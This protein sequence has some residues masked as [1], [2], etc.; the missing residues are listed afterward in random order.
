[1]K[2]LEQPGQPSSWRGLV[3]TYRLVEDGSRTGIQCLGCGLTSW[4]RNDVEMRYCGNCHDFHLPG[5]Q[6][7]TVQRGGQ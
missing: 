4:N 7:P 6:A 3:H 5:R 1:M 2:D